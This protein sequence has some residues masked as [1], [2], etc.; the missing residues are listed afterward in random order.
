MEKVSEL[1]QKGKLKLHQLPETDPAEIVVPFI[2]DKID[3]LWA[4]NENL[5]RI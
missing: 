2:N 1:V 3:S 5:Q 4:E